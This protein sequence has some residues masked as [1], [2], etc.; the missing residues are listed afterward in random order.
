MGEHAMVVLAGIGLTGLLCQ[1]LA[2]RLKLPAILFLLVA[3]LLAG[4]VTGW[5][6]PDALFGALLTVL[7]FNFIVSSHRMP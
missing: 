3:G 2:W 6:D 5:L 7:V 1:G 4:P